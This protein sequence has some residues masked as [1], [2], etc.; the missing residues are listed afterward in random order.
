MPRSSKIA[1]VCPRFS[2]GGT[3]GGAETLL[4]RLAECAAADGREVDFLTTCAQDHFSWSNAREPGIEK[5]ENLNIH[6]FRVNEDRDISR[7]LTVQDAIS[8]DG[9]FDEEDEELW[10]LNNVNSDELNQYLKTA[11]EKYDRIVMG[12]YLFGLIYYASLIHPQK[13]LLVPCLHDEPF[14][15]L[16]IMRRMFESVRGFIFNSEP[17]ADLARGIFAID[18]KEQSVVGMGLDPF[19]VHPDSFRNKHGIESPYLI[20]CGRREPLKGTPLLCDYVNAYRRRTGR[21]LKLVLTGS[22][23]VDAPSELE[24]HIID[25]G[26]VSEEVK[27][28]ALA[29]ATA[30]VHPS[31]NES[32]GIVL[33]ESWLARTPALVH[34]K[35]AV[36]RWQCEQSDGGLWFRTYP[37]FEE[38]L[39]LLL[40]HTELRDAMGESGRRYVV[41]KYSWYDVGKRLLRALDGEDAV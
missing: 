13:T 32:F 15:Y 22:G 4:R 19:D 6:Y 38:A 31:V 8:N 17:E 41:D 29:G 36:L 33:L 30:F 11:G 3:I 1:F 5:H 26:F 28:E 7:F 27:R 37:E 9:F 18:D 34:A 14:A 35:S 10:M 24:E 20:Y 16:K 2:P 23:V 25:L 21:D 12:P 40:D 39:N